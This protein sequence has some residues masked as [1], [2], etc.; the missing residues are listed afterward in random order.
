[1]TSYDMKLL[2][3]KAKSLYDDNSVV[4]EIEEKGT[5]IVT[6]KEPYNGSF[7]WRCKLINKPYQNRQ[8]FTYQV[9]YIEPL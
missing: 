2:P 9:E 3:E 7:K 8:S 4:I 1:M 6:F 5:V